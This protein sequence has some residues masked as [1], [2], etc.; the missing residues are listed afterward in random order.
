MRFTQIFFI[1]VL[2]YY[3]KN[4]VTLPILIF[5]GISLLVIYIYPSS[6][7]TLSLWVDIAT[8]F[9][10]REVS[11][12]QSNVLLRSDYIPLKFKNVHLHNVNS[13]LN[14]AYFSTSCLNLEEN[15]HNINFKPEVVYPNADLNKEEII[16]TNEN[17]SG[18]YRWINLNSGFMYVGS[19][20]NLAKRLRYY[21]NYS[22][23]TKK[24]MV[25]HKAI[26]KYGYSN[27]KLEI[28][29]YCAPEECIKREQYYLD[30]FEPEYNIL[31][32]AGSTLGYKHTEETIAKFK[33]KKPTA[34]QLI[35]L[36]AHLA[37]LNKSEKQRLGAK[38]R[39]VK[40]NE[41]K[42]IKVEV[43]DLRTNEII[44]YNSMRKATEALNTDI[45]AFQYNEK[46][47]KERGS[48][49]PFKKHFII[50]IKRDTS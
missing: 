38:E 4:I 39:M 2:Q 25:I 37:E 30:L 32:T 21:Y 11:R 26:L 45:K 13:T 47:Q 3:R 28:L 49:V 41:A 36:R 48:I 7:M 1:I 8:D 23:L 19:S 6:I 33:Q 29:E 50:K 44:I 15:N 46:V 16:K 10:G 24:N 22:S 18:V 40:L 17:K 5:L 35:K 43:T 20:V 42:G 27:F 34:D 12:M 9:F 14:K 31:K